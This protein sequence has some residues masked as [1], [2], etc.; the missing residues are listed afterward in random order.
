MTTKI[1]IALFDKV[2]ALD[3]LGPYGVLA[4]LPDS[5]I[6]FVG[7]QA[8]P[9]LDSRGRLGMIAH[10]AYDEVMDPDVIVVPGGVITVEMSREGTH[11]IIEWIRQVH[12]TTEWTTSVC[13]GAQLLGAAGILDGVPA[14]SHWYVRDDL[15]R[16]GAIPTEERVVHHGK[17]VTAAGVSA[18]IDMAL[19]L[20]ADL[21]SDVIA[22]AI[23]LTI[24]YDPAPP[25]D[26]GSPKTAPPAIVEMISAGFAGAI[27]AQNE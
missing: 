21:R 11:P 16:F 18:G 17:I 9:I 24:E 27:E 4:D 7:E 26:A 20:V 25:F 19:E 3:A 12:P 2:T 14:T 15:T 5:E 23:Q 10:G 1:A 13:T 6:V 8:G 22:Q